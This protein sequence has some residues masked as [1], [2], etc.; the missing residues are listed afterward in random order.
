MAAL[1]DDYSFLDPQPLVDNR[2][3]SHAPTERKRAASV[4]EVSVPVRV[5][6]ENWELDFWAKVFVFVI[7]L[8]VGLFV[9]DRVYITPPSTVNEVWLLGILVITASFF[10]FLRSVL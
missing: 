9:F 8:E 4:A 2:D 6:E 10:L 7:L 5:A 3:P 1:E